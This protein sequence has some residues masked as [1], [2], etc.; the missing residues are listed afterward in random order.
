MDRITL[1]G[2]DDE[3]CPVP[4]WNKEDT[5]WT[6]FCAPRNVE[7]FAKLA[8]SFINKHSN[9]NI[10]VVSQRYFFA[11]WNMPIQHTL[12]C[13][14]DMIFIDI[15]YL[16]DPNKYESHNETYCKEELR[17]FLRTRPEGCASHLLFYENIDDLDKLA[18]F[19][20]KFC[21]IGTP[22]PKYSLLRQR[23]NT[24]LRS[25]HIT[26]SVSNSS[27][28]TYEYDFQLDTTLAIKFSLKN[29]IRS[30][31]DFF[32][33]IEARVIELLSKR[34]F[35]C[36]AREDRLFVEKL[37]RV[38]ISKG[39]YVWYSEWSLAAGDSIVDKINQGIRD[40]SFMGVVFSKSSVN[41]P[42][43]RREMNAGLQSQLCG[44]GIKI[45]PILLEEC[46]VP[47]LFADLLWADFRDSFDSG[48]EILLSALIR[49]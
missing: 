16:Y 1:V 39:F 4:P 5:I 49:N 43:C 9:L 22:T 33:N 27:N 26:P 28:V 24:L 31:P 17:C 46:S 19:A 12:M 7:L 42:W 13:R 47:P 10:T 48:V 18:N 40:C 25:L 21:V 32:N 15:S 35:L 20:V 11:P 29:S 37:A 45:I 44:K 3:C 41:K 2:R 8:E 14:S 6:F 36:H 30:F 23:W 34:I 38:L